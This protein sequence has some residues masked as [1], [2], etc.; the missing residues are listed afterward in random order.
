MW[1]CV[2]VRACVC[3]CIG[4]YVCVYTIDYNWFKSVYIHMYLL[5]YTQY[6]PCECITPTTGH[7]PPTF[8]FIG[9]FIEGELLLHGLHHKPVYPLT[10][11]AKSLHCFLHEHTCTPYTVCTFVLYVHI[12]YY[13]IVVPP[14]SRV[15]GK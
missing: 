6:T 9:R 3:V 10:E 4:T 2:C 11:V 7:R 8:E 14:F 12:I 15:H 5:T 1:R 13:V